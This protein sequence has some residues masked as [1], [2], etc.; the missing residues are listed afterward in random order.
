MGYGA[1][2]AA[3]LSGEDLN[4]AI[5]D[6]D[7]DDDASMW[8]R[9]WQGWVMDLWVHPRQIAVKRMVDRWWSR[10]GLLVFLPAALVSFLFG[11]CSSFYCLFFICF[12]GRSWP[13]Y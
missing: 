11:L 12:L 6:D 3:Q 2:V 1:L 5:D 8:E 13:L 10:Y 4:D 7:Y 9:I